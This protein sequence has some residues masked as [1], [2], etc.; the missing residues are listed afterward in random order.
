MSS[1]IFKLQERFDSPFF[2]SLITTKLSRRETAQRL[3]GR[4]ERRVMH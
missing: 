4:L 2:L 1:E 3:S